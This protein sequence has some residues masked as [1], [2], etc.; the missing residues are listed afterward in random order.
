VKNIAACDIAGTALESLTAAKSVDG[1]VAAL[2]KR[3][4][5]R[6]PNVIPAGA[7]Y[8]Q[9]TEERRRS[10]SHYTPRSLTE[11]IVR[12][13]LRPI[14]EAMGERPTPDQIL[15][16]KICDPAMGSGAFLVEACRLLGD[17]LVA[18]WNAHG[19]IP[20]IPPDEDPQL[21][22]RRIVAQR[23]LYGVDKNPF[24]VDLAKLS[25]WLTTLA[26][27]HPFTFL[28]HALRC[29]DSLVGLTRE[30]IACFNW[31]VGIQIPTVRPVIDAA[32]KEAEELRAKIHAL[33][34][35]DDTDEKARLLMQAED[36]LDSVRLIGDLAIAAFFGA[37]RKKDREELR[38]RYETK[39]R[40]FIAAAKQGDGTTA[41]QELHALV[42]ETLGGA[43]PIHPF[44]WEIEFPEVFSRENPGFDAF[45]GNPPFAGKNS[46]SASNGAHYIP[47]LQ[48]IHE[49]THGNADLVSHFFRRVFDKLRVNGAFGLIATNTIAQGDTRATGLTWVCTHGGT[50][51]AAHKRVRWPGQGSGRAAV[52]VS[53]IHIAKG[54]AEPP[55]YLDGK[56]VQ[57][58]SAFLF[59]AGGDE[60]PIPLA[61]NQRKSFI[62][63]YLLGMGFTFADANPNANT[64][65]EM[66]DLIMQNP[67]NRDRILP[68]IGGEELNESP[69]QMHRR[70]VI[71]FGEMTEVEA[72]R[73]PELIHIV[74]TRVKPNR[75]SDKRESY[76]RYWW[77]FAEKRPALY[78]AIAGADKVLALARVTQQIALAFLP[79]NWV[80][81][82][83]LVIFPLASYSAF[84]VIQSRCHELWAKFL[85]S[86]LQEGLRYTPSDC[87]ETFPFPGGSD[88]NQA[89]ERNGKQYY[90]FRADLMVRNNEG[91]T[92]TYNRFH[93]PDER[94]PDI[95][96]LRELHNAMDRA[97]LD[98]YGWTDL[99][100][101]CEFILDY[102]EEED[103]DGKP[104]RKKKPWRYRWPDEFRDEVL[105]RLLA[106]N[107]QR[108]AEEKAMDVAANG[109]KKKGSRAGR[110]PR[111]SRTTTFLE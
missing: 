43:K 6:T 4:S 82:E 54:R 49:A 106:L 33:A 30:Q 109:P 8:L 103:D 32:V 73:W 111:D 84:C 9:P 101:T 56:P 3:I 90:D 61:A 52:T 15:D 46:I 58:I 36:A 75:L 88:A 25:L 10:G 12:T 77:Q 21:Y 72:R 108:A 34:A 67:K 44:H 45:I 1:L 39:V 97:V 79:S 85:S 93:N 70:Y 24:A 71:N 14:F 7:L 74:E 62:G 50:I 63:T 26:R 29:G 92:A 102:E 104:R 65:D 13:T 81:S 100:P 51:F 96:K 27:D 95:F 37:E 28:D 76:K 42:L 68:Y 47:Y 31:E 99:R 17:R 23:C 19:G 66:H 69:N 53:V 64:L 60:D 83:D 11:P 80:Y 94:A 5:K 35:S 22:A 98:A 18:A 48:N 86:T 110:K 87:F 59:H 107:Q 91:L 2:S 78:E 40:N 20:K 89:I 105:A 57:R 38:G 41:K 55:H 16:L